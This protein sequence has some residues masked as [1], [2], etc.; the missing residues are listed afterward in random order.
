MFQ[1]LKCCNVLQ[2]TFLVC[3]MLIASC[4][5]L[6]RQGKT[7]A[8]TGPPA[9]RH[10]GGRRDSSWGEYRLIQRVD[11]RG[12]QSG[13][14]YTVQIFY[15]ADLDRFRADVILDGVR[16][17]NLFNR[18][19]LSDPEEPIQVGVKEDKGEEVITINQC[20]LRS[21][22]QDVDTSAMYDALDALIREW[23]KGWRYKISLKPPEGLLR[24]HYRA[25]VLQ[26]SLGIRTVIGRYLVSTSGEL[27]SIDRL[28]LLPQL[29]D[30][31]GVPAKT[32]K[33]R[34]AIARDVIQLVEPS[35]SLVISSLDD[36]PCYDMNPLEQDMQPLI[37]P[38]WSYVDEKRQAHHIYYAYAP[39]G[40]HVL[41]Y[42]FTFR[43]EGGFSAV[44][45]IMLGTLVGAYSVLM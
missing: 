14:T 17:K 11:V 1:R 30:A 38:H 12:P 19:T 35:K 21:T 45:R 26:E 6:D 25:E 39:L 13:K 27:T 32:E 37:R 7:T 42:K 23:G 44:K 41:R 3:L 40:G 8:G 31:E 18:F 29:Y 4:C 22:R 36:I 2:C 10:G 20:S 33:D 15:I 28:T 43:A 24:N 5:H 9:P 16:Q 34:D